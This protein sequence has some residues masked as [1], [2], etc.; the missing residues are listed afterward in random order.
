MLVESVTNIHK[1]LSSNP[2]SSIEDVEGQ[3]ERGEE[4]E[5]EKE[6]IGWEKGGKNERT[7]EEK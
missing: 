7:E 2:I 3:G 5:R 1:T 4:E 6:E